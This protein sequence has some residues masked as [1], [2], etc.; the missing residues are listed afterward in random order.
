MYYRHRKEVFSVWCKRSDN[1]VN[2]Y[3]E[4]VQTYKEHQTS[5]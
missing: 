5:Q 1:F 3:Q 4:T 2:I